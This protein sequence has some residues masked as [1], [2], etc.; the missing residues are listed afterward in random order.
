M[1]P[2]A[3]RGYVDHTPL[4]TTSIPGFVEDNWGLRATSAGAAA[5]LGSAFDF[6]RAPRRAEIIGST[7]PAAPAARSETGVVF[8]LYGA[9]LLGALV[10]LASIAWRRR[11]RTEL[12]LP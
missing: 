4:Q 11:R 12:V 10:V 1:S 6:N 5:G 3:R 2:Y 7:A 8:V 9:A